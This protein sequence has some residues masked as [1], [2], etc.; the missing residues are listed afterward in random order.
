MDLLNHGLKPVVIGSTDSPVT[1][2]LQ[3]EV[4][5]LSGFVIR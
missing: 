5:V 2:D 3:S 4:Q 1:S